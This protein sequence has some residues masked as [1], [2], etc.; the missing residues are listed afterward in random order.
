MT[1]SGV[2]VNVGAFDGDRAGVFGSQA[3]EQLVHESTY[4]WGMLR[5]RGVDPD[6]WTALRR[7]SVGASW[8]A[9]LLLQTN[10]GA[11][12]LHK[13]QPA[14][15]ATRSVDAT[16]CGALAQP[17]WHAPASEGTQPFEFAISP[18][19]VA[20]AEGALLDL[21]GVEVT[22]GLQWQVAADDDHEGMWY[23]SRIFQVA[24]MI[25]GVAVDG[26]VGCDEV[27][28]APGRQNYIDD[29]LTMTHLSGAWCTWAT[30]YHDGS[31]E[32][33]HAAFGRNGFGFGLR[34]ADGAV[35]A[36]TA[37]SGTVIRDDR[38]CPT[39]ISFTIDG[40]EWEFDS[41]E[42]GM[43]EQALPG[44]VRQAE[45]WFRRVGESRRPVVWCA[46][47]EIPAAEA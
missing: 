20:W 8:P 7:M 5:S 21:A 33:G 26:F 40:E 6:I 18:A 38:G 16:E 28:L 2:N 43:P 24:G 34:A 44:P 32:A 17:A 47:P 45:G 30:A 19:G 12:G 25:D 27:H 29:P 23:R 13:H 14:L 31:V 9:R 35:S 22:P 10:A 36:T 11:D 15:Q 3:A 1:E 37:V 41:D 46:T 39:H 4:L 42:R